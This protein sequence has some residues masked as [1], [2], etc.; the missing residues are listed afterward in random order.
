M[1]YRP[2]NHPGFGK[3][4]N[5]RDQPDVVDPQYGI[6]CLNVVFTELGAVK[7][8]DGYDNHT[9]SALTNTVDSLYPYYES[10]GTNQILAGCGTRLEAVNTSGA[11]VASLTGLTGGPW[12]FIRF[13]AP[14][15][16]RAYAGNGT[17]TLRKWD[18]AAWTAPTATVDGVGALAMPKARYLAV[19]GRSNR[20]VASGFATT[21]GGPNGSTS[22]PSHVYFSDAGAPETWQ[23]TSVPATPLYQN[24]V[25]LTPGDGE[26]IQAVVSWRE[27]V[28]VFKESKFFVFYGE[29][30]DSAGGPVFDYRTVDA[31]VGLASPRAIA[32]GREGVYFLHQSGVYVTTGQE[33]QQVSDVVDPFFNGQTSDF[34]LGGSLNYAQITQC[35]MAWHDERLYLSVPGTGATTNNRTLVY[36]PRY[37]WWSLWDVAA[38]ALCSW[39]PAG[40]PRLMFGYATG[41]KHIGLLSPSFTTDDGTT[42][43]ARWR[44]GFHDEG[45]PDVKTVRELKVWGKG[46]CTVALGADF[47]PQGTGD[48]CD[49]SVTADTWGD[50]NWGAGTWGGVGSLRAKKI[51]RAV[52][53]TMFSLSVS[54]YDA[55]PFT[56]DRVT[57][58]LREQR[59]PSTLKADYV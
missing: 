40:Q 58:E 43:V 46:K 3:G 42:I 56:L 10:D 12:Q 21:T 26:K 41:A 20:L 16:E 30:T 53:G 27:Y 57:Y 5:L 37:G 39:R 33:P 54:N 36:D 28:F 1:S 47:R 14:N 31:G 15:S 19:M 35:A 49:F 2:F 4:L 6:D 59:V 48:L 34:Y 22:S 38:S 24:A 25:Q 7:T 23:V 13:G 11:V 50:E 29:S 45:I 32:V 44:S 55:T 9:S 52:R 51:R 17:D 8:R 18:G